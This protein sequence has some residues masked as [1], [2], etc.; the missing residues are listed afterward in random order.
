[1]RCTKTSHIKAKVP[2]NEDAMTFS[3]WKKS[4]SHKTL[5][6]HVQHELPDVLCPAGLLLNFLGRFRRKRGPRTRNDYGPIK[7]SVAHS[8]S[9]Y[10]S[11]SLFALRKSDGT[12]RRWHVPVVFALVVLGTQFP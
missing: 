10:L 7:D 12:H 5:L 3:A 9:H 2:N 6:S 1:M 11:L 4:P 8:G